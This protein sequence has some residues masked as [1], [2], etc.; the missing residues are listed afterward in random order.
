LKGEI[1]KVGIKYRGV[2]FR[3]RNDTI[4]YIFY[5]LTSE[6]NQKKIFDHIVVIGD[7]I[8][9]RKHSDTLILRKKNIDLIYTFIKF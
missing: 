4:E 6:L 5:P 8:I 1:Q 2:G 9:K 3:L 7:S